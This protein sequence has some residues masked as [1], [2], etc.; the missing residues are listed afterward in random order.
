MA[1]EK[2][3]F[4]CLSHRK[5]CAFLRAE[6]TCITSLTELQSNKRETRNASRLGPVEITDLGREAFLTTCLTTA[7]D[8]MGGKCEIKDG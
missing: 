7:R 8:G 2:T 5:L 3:I 1:K 4:L 6:N